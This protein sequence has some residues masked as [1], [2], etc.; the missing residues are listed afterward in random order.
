MSA[1]MPGSAWKLRQDQFAFE[2]IPV[3]D[4]VMMGHGELWRVKEERDAIYANPDASEAD[5]MHA[6]E[7]ESRFAELD[8]YSAE[9]APGNC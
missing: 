7:L 8:G 2:E 5:Y 1:S 4:T 9:R 3:I 6:A